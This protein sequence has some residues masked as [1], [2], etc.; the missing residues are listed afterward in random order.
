MTKRF[1]AVTRGV[2]FSG[3]FLLAL[4][5]SAAEPGP[6]AM[7]TPTFGSDL[8]PA[9]FPRLHAL[10]RPHTKEWRHLQVH[11]LTDVT[12]ARKRATEEDRPIVICYTG[13]AGYNE[14]L[15]VC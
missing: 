8:T 5:A 11:W 14:P 7:T 1:L 15:G 10:I 13:G 12:A 9:T 2:L 3:S 6:N 4:P